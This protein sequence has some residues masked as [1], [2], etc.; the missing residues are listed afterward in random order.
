[1]VGRTSVP[2]VFHSRADL[3]LWIKSLRESGQTL[4]LVPT[5]GNLHTGHLA[6]VEQAKNEADNVLVSIF[7]NPTQFGANEDYSTYPRTLAQDFEALST[8]KASAAW[9]PAIEEI[10]PNGVEGSVAIDVPLLSHVLCG[11]HRP[12]HFSGVAGVVTRLLQITQPDVAVFGEK[13]YQQL[14]VVRKVV[15]ELFLQVRIRSIPTMREADGLAMSSRNRY[16][17]DSERRQAP[18]L[19]DALN[20]A[21]SA[22]RSGQNQVAVESRGVA[23]L[24][25]ANFRPEYFSIRSGEDLGPPKSGSP[26]RVFA[27]AWLGAARLIDNVAV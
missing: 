19:Y 15:E 18:L 4:A 10:Y 6:L 7:V 1:M 22:V 20:E 27:A 24:K 2:V 5:M 3:D 8:V 11:L 13:D 16:L 23:R 9:L 17:T 26:I 12:H 21:A 14:L 25:D